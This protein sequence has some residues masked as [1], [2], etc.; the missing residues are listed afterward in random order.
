MST[1]AIEQAK[2]NREAAYL[3]TADAE[4]TRLVVLLWQRPTIPDAIGIPPSLWGALK[5]EGDT[6]PLFQLGRRLFVRTEDLRAW[7]DAKAKQARSRSKRI[8][9][10]V[11]IENPIN[12]GE[13]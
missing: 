3:A 11:R 12:R 6:P 5:A 13:Q 1:E 10:Q 7:L 2:T 4:Q 8:R 9:A